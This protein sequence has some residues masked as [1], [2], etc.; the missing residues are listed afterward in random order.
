LGNNV[1]KIFHKEE[2]EFFLTEEGMEQEK[3][4]KDGGR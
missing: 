2:G 1:N 3:M 4:E